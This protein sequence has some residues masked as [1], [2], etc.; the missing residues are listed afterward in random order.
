MLGTLDHTSWCLPVD[1]GML[2]WEGS[3]NS[4]VKTQMLLIYR[5]LL[6]SQLC[7]LSNRIAFSV[8]GETE[9]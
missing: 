3:V 5:S 9:T 8:V 2:L 4:T 7:S 1:V 6:S